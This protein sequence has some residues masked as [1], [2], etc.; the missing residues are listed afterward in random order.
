MDHAPLTD[1]MPD[2][3]GCAGAQ[4]CVNELWNVPIEQI[5]LAVQNVHSARGAMKNRMV[6][7]YKKLSEAVDRWAAVTIPVLYLVS[8]IVV[9]QIEL[10]DDYL[11]N[12]DRLMDGSAIKVERFTTVGI[13]QLTL[14]ALALTLVLFAAWLMR[15]IGRRQ[16][17]NK[18]LKEQA[19][20]EELQ[21]SFTQHLKRHVS[22]E[23]TLARQHT[24]LRLS[25]MS[26][27]DIRVGGL[28]ETPQRASPS[29]VL[30]A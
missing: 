1:T 9:F 5:N 10:S 15:R 11:T 19:K 4:L 17:E 29:Q 28:A 27:G 14:F 23:Q 7:K 26:A 16:V 22:K 8:Q 2:R 30:A 18:R 12:S 24:A 3:N 20:V 6:A 13:I 21:Q 25:R